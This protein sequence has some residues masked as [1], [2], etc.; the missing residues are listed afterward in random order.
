MTSIADI[1]PWGDR[2]LVAPAAVRHET[3]SGIIIPDQARDVVQTGTVLAVGSDQTHPS[4]QP[5][6]EIIFARHGGTSFDIDRTRYLVLNP[7]DILA[8]VST[9]QEERDARAQQRQ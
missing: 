8:V 3:P 5:G 9:S 7:V 1:Q 2:V 4:L 6:T